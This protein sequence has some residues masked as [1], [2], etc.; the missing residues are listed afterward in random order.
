MG[1]KIVRMV[2]GPV[3]GQGAW[4]MRT[5]QELRELHKTPC[6]AIIPFTGY[7]RTFH[8]GQMTTICNTYFRKIYKV[9]IVQSV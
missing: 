6:L 9:G 4:R 7:D 5:N 3:T 1:T 2:Y 8:H